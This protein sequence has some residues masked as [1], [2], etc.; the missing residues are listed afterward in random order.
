MITL[1]LLIALALGQVATIAAGV[2]A[3]RYVRRETDVA[4]E[5]EIEQSLRQSVAELLAELE[6]STERAAQGLSRQRA[7]LTKLLREADRR[8]QVLPDAPVEP[9]RSSSG[10]STD[11]ALQ[12]V[13][14]NARL[15]SEWQDVALRLAH[16]GLAEA[17][18][19]RQLRVGLED[20]RLTLA[21]R[22]PGSA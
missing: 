16:E 3:Y 5:T 7:T 10:F 15:A 13:T 17:T 19:A 20:V 8:I 21:T 18:I 12:T 22:M 2:M 1:I 14:R 4:R 6:A 11:T 9:G